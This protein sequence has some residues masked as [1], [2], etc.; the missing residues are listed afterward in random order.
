MGKGKP[1]LVIDPGHGGRDP[2]AIDPIYGIQEKRITLNVALYLKEWAL[3]K[4]SFTPYLT[5]D[6]DSHVSLDERCFTSNACG[7]DAFLSI[8]CNAR[9]RRG[10]PGIEIEAYHFPGSE[11]GRIF[12]GLISNKLEDQLLLRGE[13]F[14]N[15]GVK[16]YP[17][18]VLKHTKAPAVLV[19]LGFLSDPE[20]AVWL[21]GSKN[22]EALAAALGV[23]SERF[24]LGGQCS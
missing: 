8:H 21:V 24:L 14:F 9:E 15:R 20:E 1:V 6:D 18:Y 23:A 10:K 11:K 22:Q 12:A 3:R 5:R 16:T 13:P 19:E 17:Y 4:G 7:A 2:G